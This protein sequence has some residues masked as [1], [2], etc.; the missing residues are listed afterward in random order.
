MMTKRIMVTEWY[1]PFKL[2][3]RFS[4]GKNHHLWSLS[5]HTAIKT[6]MSLKGR[7]KSPLRNPDMDYHGV[8]FLYPSRSTQFYVLRTLHTMKKPF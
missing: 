8:F 4:R 1:L 2:F 3:N 5:I 7:T 6:P